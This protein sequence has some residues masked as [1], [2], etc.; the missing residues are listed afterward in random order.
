MPSKHENPESARLAVASDVD[1]TKIIEC[2]RN[3]DEAARS[4]LYSQVYGDLR[5]LARHFLRGERSGHTLQAT[6]LVNESYRR[7][8][9]NSPIEI[10]DRRHFFALAA[11]IMRR[12]LVDHARSRMSRAEA[13]KGLLEQQALEV[14]DSSDLV[15]LD[16][17]LKK[18]EAIG[19]RQC[20][21]VE[22]RFF[23]GMSEKE[24]ADILGVSERTIKR[25]WQFA[26]A[27]L[28]EH[29]SGRR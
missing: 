27:W 11:R 18:L 21:V 28:Y 1:L 24:I 29:V 4:L 10:H 3:G 8:F 22:M 9:G 15:A 23:V 16:D 20:R 12:I 13:E 5:K 25:D 19:E 14:R 26:K 7:L 2:A 6:E 17:A